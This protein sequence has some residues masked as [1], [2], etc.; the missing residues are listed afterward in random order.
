MYL[1]ETL[2]WCTYVLCM[3]PCEFLVHHACL[4]VMDQEITLLHLVMSK[5][6][7][8]RINRCSVTNYDDY[9]YS[10][11]KDQFR[12]LESAARRQYVLTD[13]LMPAYMAVRRSSTW[14][15]NNRTNTNENK[16]NPKD[17]NGVCVKQEP[18]P[19]YYI[20]LVV[21]G[22]WCW[23]GMREKYCWLINWQISKRT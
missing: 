16:R 19:P 2:H 14:I 1:I 5:M 23:F 9:Y 18:L 20:R 21:V 12:S 13:W 22:G 4:H 3:Y 6:A 11:W 15:S 10:N 17:Y 7:R 8:N